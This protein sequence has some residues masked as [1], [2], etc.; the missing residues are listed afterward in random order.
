MGPVYNSH[1][2]NLET[3]QFKPLQGGHLSKADKNFC[4]VSVRFR[5]VPLYVIY[6]SVWNHKETSQLTTTLAEWLTP[7]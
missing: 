4:P 1:T 5:E 2:L 7:M 6:V 3:F